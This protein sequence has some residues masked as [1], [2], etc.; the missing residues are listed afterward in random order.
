MAKRKKLNPSEVIATA[1][2][3][4]APPTPANPQPQPTP[5]YLTPESAFPAMV[6]GA[7]AA[8]RQVEFLNR[9]TQ[10]L[11]TYRRLHPDRYAHVVAFTENLSDSPT[12]EEM[13]KILDKARE[14]FGE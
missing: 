4:A 14:I 8:L 13:T 2:A 12:A 7:F 5:D 10:R 6:Q 11:Q 3:N 1:F 9:F